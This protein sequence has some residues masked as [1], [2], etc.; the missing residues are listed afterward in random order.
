[1]AALSADRKERSI[2]FQS[3]MRVTLGDLKAAIEKEI[4]DK[5][6]VFQDLGEN[7]YLLELEAKTDAENLINN[8]FDVAEIHVDCSPPHGKFLNVSIMGLRSYIHD[9]EVIDALT[10]YGEIKS[11]VIRL[12]YKADHE[13]AGLENG[14]RLVKMVLAA[15]SLPYSMKIGGEWCRIIHSN[16]QPVCLEC[17]ELGHTKKRCPKIRCRVCHQLGHMSYNCDQQEF[18]DLSES[19]GGQQDPGEHEQQQES[20]NEEN[21]QGESAMADSAPEEMGSEEAKKGLK[22]QHVTDSDSDRKPNTTA[23]RQRLNP[24]PKLTT[25]KKDGKS[26]SKSD[27]MSSKSESKSPTT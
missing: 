26:V 12:K 5:I 16:Q 15:P 3:P 14:N 13:L 21:V 18:N 20:Q 4:N 8:G 24:Q 19:T 9:A 23:R 25:R 1:M 27:G 17:N 11:E 22:R 2:T 10:E 7:V 6:N